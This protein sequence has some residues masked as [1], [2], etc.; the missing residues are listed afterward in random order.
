MPRWSK[1]ALNDLRAQLALI[2]RENPEAARCVA[3]QIKNAVESLDSFPQLGR[4]GAVQGTKE[5]VVP[6]IPFVCVYRERDGQVE[7]LRLLHERMQ[8][9]R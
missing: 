6:R 1:P 9:P 5:L 4:D 7:I 8:W 2:Q 3:A